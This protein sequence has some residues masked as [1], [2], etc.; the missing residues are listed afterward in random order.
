[1]RYKRKLRSRKQSGGML[2]NETRA[3]LEDELERLQDEYERIKRCS[4]GVYCKEDGET[5][6][7][8]HCENPMKYGLLEDLSDKIKV[9]K[10]KLEN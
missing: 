10:D 9:I 7:C 3:L 8:I 4:K 2:K 6:Y 5:R 1:M